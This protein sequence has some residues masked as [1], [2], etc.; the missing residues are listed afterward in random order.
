MWYNKLMN[1]NELKMKANEYKIL[2]QA[3]AKDNL[4][5]TPFENKAKDLSMIKYMHDVINNGITLTA[6]YDGSSKVYTYMP[7]YEAE[8]IEMVYIISKSLNND[9]TELHELE[10]MKSDSLIF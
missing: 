8:A 3:R 1:D 6:C 5:M 7:E 2:L 10:R 4:L 9:Y